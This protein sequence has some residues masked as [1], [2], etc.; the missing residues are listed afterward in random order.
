MSGWGSSA[1]GGGSAN[2]AAWCRAICSRRRPAAICRAEERD[3]LAGLLQ[4]QTKSLRDI[5]KILGR[6]PS[7]IS[8]ELRRNRSD[9]RSPAAHPARQ[10]GQPTGRRG[11]ILKRHN[12]Q[13]LRAQRLAEAR[14]REQAPASKL[15]RIPRLHAEVQRRLELDHSPEQIS[16]CLKTEFADDGQMQISTESIYRSLYVQGKGELNRELTRHLRTG[17]ALRKPRRRSDQRRG[18]IP[19]MIN[20]RER[21][22]E[23]ADRAVP[24]HW[25]GDLIIG[26]DSASA[27]GTL[28]ERTSGFVML[29]HLPH[30]HTADA[31]EQAMIT[32]ISQLPKTLAKTLTWDQG[33]EMANHA[34]IADATGL[35]IYF[36]D[37][38][39]P[40]QRGTNENTNGLL[41]QYFPKGTD[42]SGYHPDYLDWVA[43]RLNNRPRK[44]HG[45][46]T[47][48]Q[49]LDQLL[50]NPPTISVATPA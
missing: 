14:R 3:Q 32:A 7:T 47:P 40:W 18:R 43:T 34:R 37:P 8:R 17:R 28:V 22:A 19:N 5:A 6:S 33:K 46:K 41:R 13:P 25:E 36:C 16:N 11:R 9:T 10:P 4:D 38:H 31:V 2:L 35:S 29:L 50:S 21:P 48:A 30:S 49:A 26:K 39:S 12:Y 20:I 1:A 23:I 44:R 27:I 15:T 24:G 45:W 42:L